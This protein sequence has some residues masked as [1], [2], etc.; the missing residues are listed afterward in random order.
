MWTQ[1]VDMIKCKG[2]WEHT[3]G[4]HAKLGVTEG[5]AGAWTSRLEPETSEE[6]SRRDCG[7]M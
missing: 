3:P 6:E 7:E 5:Y 1:H 4:Q 2:L